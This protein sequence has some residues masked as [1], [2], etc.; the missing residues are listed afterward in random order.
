MLYTGD[1][2]TRCSIIFRDLGF[3]N[4]L[5]IELTRHNKIGRLVKAGHSLGTTRLSKTDPGI[6]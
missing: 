3:D 4:N 5:G 1:L 2:I 6:R